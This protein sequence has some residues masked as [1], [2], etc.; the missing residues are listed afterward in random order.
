MISN[1]E[2]KLRHGEYDFNTHKIGSGPQRVILKLWNLIPT[3]TSMIRHVRV[4]FIHERV[5][6]WSEWVWFWHTSMIRHV[7][8]RFKDARARFWNAACDFNTL[9]CDFCT[10]EY[11]LTRM[12]VI[13]TGNSMIP[14]HWMSFRYAE[15]DFNT[16]ELGCGTQRVI[17]TLNVI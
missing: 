1:R 5:R 13:K 15:R 11:I 9:E 7:R 8:V 3:H 6:F 16:H 14:T 10:N 4:W 17:L 12:S 2:T